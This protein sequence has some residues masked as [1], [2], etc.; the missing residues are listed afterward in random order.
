MTTRIFKIKVVEVDCERLYYL[1]R[2]RR[3]SG[4]ALLSKMIHIVLRDDL[5]A[6][7]LDDGKDIADKHDSPELG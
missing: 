6:A 1:A 2:K 7:V 3:T 4:E 5:V